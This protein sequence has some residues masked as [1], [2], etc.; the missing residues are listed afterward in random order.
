[1]STYEEN[2]VGATFT[3]QLDDLEHQS[4]DASNLLKILSFFDPESIPL[5]MITQGAESLL[6]SVDHLQLKPLL[7]LIL[8]PVQLQVAITQFQNLSLVK[9][10]G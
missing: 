8:S 3:A 9:Y 7:H 5:D 2:S 10:N 6:S 4:P 1:L